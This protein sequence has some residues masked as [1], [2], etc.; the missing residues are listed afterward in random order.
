MPTAEPALLCAG[1]KKLYFHAL[2]LEVRGSEHSEMENSTA[3]YSNRTTSIRHNKHNRFLSTTNG[4]GI[5]E[6]L[7]P[8]RWCNADVHWRR[9]SNIENTSS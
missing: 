1:R 4:K 5:F 3:D 8:E 7:R 2:L 6:E 9:W